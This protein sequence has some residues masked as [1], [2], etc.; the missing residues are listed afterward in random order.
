MVSTSLGGLCFTIPSPSNTIF[1]AK[2][3]TLPHL[4][5]YGRDGEAHSV[6]FHPY[7][8]VAKILLK[9]QIEIANNAVDCCCGDILIALQIIMWTE[10]QVGFIC[11]INYDSLIN[12]DPHRQ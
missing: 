4:Y 10:V 5:L 7:F 3:K 6:L 12:E 11:E 9:S 1:P 8:T 2:S